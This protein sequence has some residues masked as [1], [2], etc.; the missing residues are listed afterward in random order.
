MVFHPQVFAEDPAKTLSNL[1]D[2]ESTAR[3]RLL[4]EFGIVISQALTA[5]WFYKLFKNINEFGAWTLGIWGTVNAVAI[6]I[7]GIAIAAAISIA[8][9]DASMDSKLMAV[10]MLQSVSANAWGVGS[11]FFGLW[12]FPMGWI[13]IKSGRMPIWLGRLVLIGGIGYVLSTIL[14]YSGADLAF[15]SYLSLPATAGEFWMI[16]YLLIFGIRPES[17]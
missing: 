6:M 1:I 13:V 14:G 3:I 15:S 8:N 4:L 11:L 17:E 5:V 7:S 2:Q 16:G 10:E 9:G 12:L